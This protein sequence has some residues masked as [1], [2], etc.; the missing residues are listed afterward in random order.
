MWMV[1]LMLS[2]RSLKLF[3]FLFIPYLFYSIAVISTNL[4]CRSLIHSS[5]SFILP[6]IASSVFSNPV[7][8]SVL[9]VLHIF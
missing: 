3:S 2:Q 6:L 8:H 9:I 5:A 1:H 7:I 4:S